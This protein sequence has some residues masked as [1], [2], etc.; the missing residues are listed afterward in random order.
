MFFLRISDLIIER[1]QQ[2]LFWSDLIYSFTNRGKLYRKCLNTIHEFTKKVI[3][4]REDEFSSFYTEKRRAFL[5][6]LLEAKNEDSRLNS[7]DLQEEVDTFMFAGHD[8][9]TSATSWACHLIGS[10]F[11]VQKKL[12]DEIDAVFGKILA[13]MCV[14]IC[15]N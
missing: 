6:I 1:V 11:D 13:N 8:T 3:N 7:T 5:D 15:F 2:P 4:E 14:S 10:H 12:H 9:T